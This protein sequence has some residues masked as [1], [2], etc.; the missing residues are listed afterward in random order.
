[1]ETDIRDRFAMAALVGLIAQSNGT[2]LTS[3]LALG[4][5]FAFDMA[6]AM[7]AEREQRD[8]AETQRRSLSLDQ[9]LSGKDQ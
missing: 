1:M 6:D 8:E 7:I 5:K 9:Y 3:T 2:A 4:A